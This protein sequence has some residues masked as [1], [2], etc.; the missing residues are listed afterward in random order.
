M[1][2]LFLSFGS[3]SHSESH[4]CQFV[5]LGVT[6]YTS[7]EFMELPVQVVWHECETSATDAQVCEVTIVD[8]HVEREGQSLGCNRR[9]HVSHV[10]RGSVF[11]TRAPRSRPQGGLSSVWETSNDLGSGSRAGLCDCFRADPGASLA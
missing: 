3:L 8:A 10:D 4:A 1:F 9:S 6:R 11:R 2:F 7:Q 5:R